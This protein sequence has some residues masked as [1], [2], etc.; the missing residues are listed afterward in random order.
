MSVQGERGAALVVALWS[1]VIL[2]LIA[3]GLTR[4]ARDDLALAR[5]LKEQVKAELAADS[6][7]SAALHALSG[8]APWPADG[9]V[10]SLVL[11]GTEIRIAVTDE[12]GRLDLNS[13]DEASLAELLRQAGEPEAAAGRLAEAIVTQRADEDMGDGEEER[14]PAFMRVRDL[15]KIPGFTPALLSRIEEAFTVHGGARSLAA[16]ETVEPEPVRPGGPAADV[17]TNEDAESATESGRDGLFRIRSEAMT[18]AGA[19]AVRIGVF[20][21]RASPL[22]AETRLWTRGERRLFPAPAY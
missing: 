1:A 11:E 13:V 10:R 4:L 2:A 12:G 3:A 21:L 16:G 9:S 6:G 5:N 20:A 22:S 18:E 7:V 17:A 15:L 14:A 8:P 19:V